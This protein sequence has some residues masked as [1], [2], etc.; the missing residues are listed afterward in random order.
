M[1]IMTIEQQK[2]KLRAVVFCV[3]AAVYMPAL[4]KAV[5]QLFM[6]AMEA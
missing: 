6:Q 5:W 3:A 2:I 1:A 4:H